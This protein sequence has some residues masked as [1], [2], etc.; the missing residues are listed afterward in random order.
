MKIIKTK[1]YLTKI[2]LPVYRPSEESMSKMEKGNIRLLHDINK[3]LPNITSKKE[4]AELIGGLGGIEGISLPK[5]FYVG[6]ENLVTYDNKKYYYLHHE[7][8]NKKS[9]TDKGKLWLLDLETGKPIKYDYYPT[10]DEIDTLGPERKKQVMETINKAI[11]EW[12]SK[13]DKF[14]KNVGLIT[15]PLRVQRTLKLIDQRLIEL[16]NQKQAIESRP[17]YGTEGSD[18]WKA[19]SLE[20][21]RSGILKDNTQDAVDTVFLWYQ[22]NPEKLLEDLPT[23]NI[24][25]DAKKILINMANREI[26]NKTKKIEKKKQQEEE[27][28]NRIEEDLPEVR[29]PVI[30]SI[31]EYKLENLPRG[32]PQKP[33]GYRSFDSRKFQGSPM[34]KGINSN[35]K[36]IENVREAL[37][38]INSQIAGMQKGQFTEEY[39]MSPKGGE[40]LSNMKFLLD[41]AYGFIKKY[42]ESIFTEEGKVNPKLFGSTGNIGNVELAVEMNRLYNAVRKAVQSRPKIY[43]KPE[44]VP[45]EVPQIASSELKI[46]GGKFVKE[47][48]TASY[49]KLSQNFEGE[50]FDS[51]TIEPIEGRT[52]D[53]EYKVVGHG[54]YERGSV[55]SGQPRRAV[56]DFFETVE[57]ALRAYPQAEV[58]EHSTKTFGETGDPG[59]IAPFRVDPA[60]AGERWDSDY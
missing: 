23:F 38:K 39:L 59:P 50:N 15:I 33:L 35:I 24:S 2:A 20:A 36:V 16:N 3:E 7:L 27:K 42:S 47:I 53:V 22:E 41:A 30:Q 52:G 40:I 19:E 48:K 57:E 13:I 14:D 1:N 25:E 58:L 11:R 26:I 29:E 45:G 17:D 9:K 46:I 54:I 34:L 49:V 56:L 18:Q 60:D 55:L 5:I 12:N 43:P 10:I 31:P 37:Q 8:P 21:L 6:D 44:T 4:F 51:L 32:E 28:K